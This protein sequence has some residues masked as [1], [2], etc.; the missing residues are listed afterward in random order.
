MLLMARVNYIHVSWNAFV[1]MC[2]N[3]SQTLVKDQATET[4]KRYLIWS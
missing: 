1:R 3:T 2:F 4:T